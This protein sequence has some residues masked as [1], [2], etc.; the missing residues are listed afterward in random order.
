MPV[1]KT[2]PI[3]T[4]VKEGFKKVGQGI[5]ESKPEFKEATSATAKELK[6]TLEVGKSRLEQMKKNGFVGSAKS[7]SHEVSSDMSKLWKGFKKLF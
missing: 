6:E 5:S 4:H 7:I 2:G 1:N 3:M